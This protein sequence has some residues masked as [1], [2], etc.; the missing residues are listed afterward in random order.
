MLK[1]RKRLSKREIKEDPLVTKYMQVKQFWI[2]HRKEFDIIVGVIAVVVI[3]GFLMMK[4]KRSAEIKANSQLA[5]PETYYHFHDYERAMPELETIIEQ[6][7][8]THSAGMAIFFLANIYY[9]KAEYDEAYNYYEMY[10]DD[11]S[12]EDIFISSCLAGKAACLENKENYKQ[13]ADLYFKAVKKYPDLFKSPYNAMN[14]VRCCWLA[15][16]N[17]K[18]K[19]FCKYIINNYPDSP[20]IQ[21]AEY[22]AEVL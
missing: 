18:G 14:A 19:E 17:N 8:G 12:E 3:I 21:K 20:V 1:P 22:F 6:Y 9:D 4:S 11:Y 13:A 7:P 5:I 10:L 15:G 16:M 2:N